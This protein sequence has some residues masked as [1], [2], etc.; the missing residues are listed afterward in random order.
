M[1]LLPTG[2]RIAGCR[3]RRPFYFLDDRL[4]PDPDIG[5][6]PPGDEFSFRIILGCGS[7]RSAL[8]CCALGGNGSR[9]GPFARATDWS[10]AFAG[11]LTRLMCHCSDCDSSLSRWYFQVTLSLST[12]RLPAL[13]CTMGHRQ[14]RRCNATFTERT[15][16][17]A[18]FTCVHSL[19][20]STCIGA[21][22]RRH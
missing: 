19:A 17:Q 3:H 4:D 22:R 11:R 1:P 12:H 5:R 6:R 20:V 14:P 7:S 2:Q 15:T 16:S 21:M 18:A 10:I 9:D 8:R 13:I